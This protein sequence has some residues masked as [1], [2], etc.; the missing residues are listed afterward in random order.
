MCRAP[1]IKNQHS[2]WMLTHDQHV[3]QISGGLVV[4]LL[5]VSCSVAVHLVHIIVGLLHHKGSQ[6]PFRPASCKSSLSEGTLSQPPNCVQ[7]QATADRHHGGCGRDGH[8]FPS[9]VLTRRTLTIFWQV[10]SHN[11]DATVITRIPRKSAYA[12]QF[13]RFPDFEKSG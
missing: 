3:F 1:L 2:V 4:S 8:T 6:C 12:M 5:F 13:S 7:S 11:F 9:V 10:F